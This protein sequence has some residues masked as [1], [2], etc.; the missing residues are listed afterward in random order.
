MKQILREK[1]PL[2][3]ICLLVVTGIV[4]AAFAYGASSTSSVAATVT[5][6]NISIS[7]SS[8]SVA[9]GS[10]ALGGSAS[11]TATGLNNT[12]NASNTGNISENFNIQ[13]QNTTNWTLAGSAGS[14]QYAHKFCNAG[15][16]TCNTS[17]TWNAL[18]TSYTA[19]STSSVA[20]GTTRPFDLQ[21]LVPSAT[22]YFTQQNPNV[23]VQAT[24]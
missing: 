6:Q 20:V 14:E 17:P 8:G 15:T 11:T 13:G 2:S 1:L 22:S 19:L 4:V 21:I 10:V 7:V 18:T 3:S 24:Q 23:T 5:A 16:S 12:Q 9:Y